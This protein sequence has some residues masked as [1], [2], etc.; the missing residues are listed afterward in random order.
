MSVHNFITLL[1]HKPTIACDC[2][3]IGTLAVDECSVDGG[4]C[5][6]KPGVGG[7]QCNRC[8]PSFYNF[9]SNGCT[10]KQDSTIDQVLIVAFF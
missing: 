5:T 8:I 6:C 1:F 10:G 7:R 9:S 4:V 3:P 2:D